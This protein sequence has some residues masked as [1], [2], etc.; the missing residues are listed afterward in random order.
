MIQSVPYIFQG[1]P[2]SLQVLRSAWS[3]K[4]QRWKFWKS[5]KMIRCFRKFFI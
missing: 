4:M 1:N 2:W 3:Y 5:L